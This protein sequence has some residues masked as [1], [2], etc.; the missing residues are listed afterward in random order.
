M[1]KVKP[2]IL[3]GVKCVLIY[4]LLVISGSYSK[5]GDKYADLF[6]S[7]GNSLVK[8]KGD[9]GKVKFQKINEKK[10][11]TKI[12]VTNSKLKEKG[13]YGVPVNTRKIGYVPTILLISLVL[14]TS[15][16][17]IRRKGIA[18]LLGVLLINV[19]IIF[20]LDVKIRFVFNEGERLLG[21]FNPSFSRKFIGLLNS[22][23]VENMGLGLIVPVFIWLIVSFK[24]SDYQNFIGLPN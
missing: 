9:T 8:E 24:K 1:F 5:L 12:K 17:T 15:F 20:I 3:F 7:K 6:R 21:Q 4:L 11:D 2:I 10:F 23:I 16:A 13:W 19:Y 18:L 22:A 14:A